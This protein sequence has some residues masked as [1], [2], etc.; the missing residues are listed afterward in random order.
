MA[1]LDAV[2]GVKESRSSAAANDLVENF[3]ET[4]AGILASANYPMHIMSAGRG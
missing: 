4:Y 1:E 2:A 3:I